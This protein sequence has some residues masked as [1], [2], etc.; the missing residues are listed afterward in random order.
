MC[1]TVN[2]IYGTVKTIEHNPNIVQNL[3]CLNMK[4]PI[5][6]FCTVDAESLIF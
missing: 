2:H 6:E 5:L 3:D 1:S 4:C